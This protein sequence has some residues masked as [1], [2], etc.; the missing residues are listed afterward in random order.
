MGYAFAKLLWITNDSGSN[1]AEKKYSMLIHGNGGIIVLIRVG[2]FRSKSLNLVDMF[3]LAIAMH[4]RHIMAF[5]FKSQTLRT[6]AFETPTIS[7][8]CF[9]TSHSPKPTGGCQNLMMKQE[10]VAVAVCHLSP[11]SRV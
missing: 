9:R 5:G 11:A 1:K 3:H 6:L 8:S 4:R 10:S 2:G 7:I